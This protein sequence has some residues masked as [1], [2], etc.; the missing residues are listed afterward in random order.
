MAPKKNPIA[1]PKKAAAAGSGSAPKKQK[2]APPRKRTL[3]GTSN[4]KAK[5]AGTGSNAKAK[6]ADD[7]LDN[8]RYT[9][10]PV[11]VD[12]DGVPDGDI[13]EKI[14]LKT[15]QVESRIFVP[16]RQIDKIVNDMKAAEKKSTNV[17]NVVVRNASPIV[18]VAD[19]TSFG[20]S[21][22]TGFGAG[23]GF[24]AANAM[25]DGVIGLF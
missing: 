25:V 22:K 4:A 1:A 23:I 24:A 13:I 20:Q 7:D 17:D 11:D 6:A 10:L 8:Y 14:N 9:V 2:A 18:K 12:G 21:L 5:A 15:K 19:K 3:G 16:K